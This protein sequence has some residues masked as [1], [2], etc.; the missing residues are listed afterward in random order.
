MRFVIIVLAVFIV[1]LFR[2]YWWQLVSN[3]GSMIIRYFG[4]ALDHTLRQEYTHASTRTHGHSGAENSEMTVFDNSR[5]W[6]M[7][8]F[9]TYCP[10]LLP[11]LI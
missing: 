8:S 4:R 6:R 9:S 1:F 10:E 2:Y 7:S 5:V 3:P 11:F